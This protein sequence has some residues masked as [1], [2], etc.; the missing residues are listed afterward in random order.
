MFAMAKTKGRQ[1]RREGEEKR[2]G[3]SR[4]GR[5]EKG[6]MDEDEA[7]QKESCFQPY[8]MYRNEVWMWMGLSI[9]ITW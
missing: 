9:H 5:E 3:A 2:R 6:G 7:G 8:R 4:K 1:E